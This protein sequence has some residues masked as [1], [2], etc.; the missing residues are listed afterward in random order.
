MD[1]T[2][3]ANLGEFIG[4]VAVLVTLIFLTTQIRYNTRSVKASV[5][6]SLA[7]SYIEVARL[8]SEDSQLV[9]RGF[10]AWDALDPGERTRMGSV[11]IAVFKHFENCWF[12]SRSR[13][14]DSEQWE[15]WDALMRTL[16]HT[17][18]AQTWWRARR[19]VFAS[20]FRDYLEST[21]PVP[22]VLPVNQMIGG[23]AGG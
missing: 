11:L 4:G 23:G 3:L 20:T 15:G 10:D 22:G 5:V 6:D 9:G 7:S 14:L 12:Q 16:F 18:G 17:P 8:V 2:Q 13:T 21:E 1:L 19:M